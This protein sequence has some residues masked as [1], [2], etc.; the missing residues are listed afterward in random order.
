MKATKMLVTRFFKCALVRR[1]LDAE[2]FEVEADI[3]NEAANDFLQPKGLLIFDEFVE[4]IKN[5]HIKFPIPI[6][7]FLTLS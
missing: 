5:I 4:I 7:K 1:S 6:P 3:L 2:L